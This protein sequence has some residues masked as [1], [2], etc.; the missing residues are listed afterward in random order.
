MADFPV[1]VFLT[2]LNPSETVWAANIVCFAQK[3]VYFSLE[4][5]SLSLQPQKRKPFLFFVFFFRENISVQCCWLID[6][7]RVVAIVI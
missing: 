2:K 3:V 4:A 1:F 7:E 6:R 5:S